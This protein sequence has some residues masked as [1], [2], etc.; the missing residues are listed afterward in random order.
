MPQKQDEYICS[1]SIHMFV[2]DCRNIDSL[3][4]FNEAKYVFDLLFIINALRSI[5][6]IRLTL[7][8]LFQVKHVKARLNK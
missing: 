6:D 1:H 7:Y 8:H 3:L 5:I 2:D 4:Y